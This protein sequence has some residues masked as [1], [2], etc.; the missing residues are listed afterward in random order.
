MIALKDVY[1]DW[2]VVS[3]SGVALLVDVA[4]VLP[5]WF[6]AAIGNEKNVDTLVDIS[7]SDVSFQPCSSLKDGSPPPPFMTFL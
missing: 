4:S 2:T 6:D 5:V 3:S 1:I 7:I